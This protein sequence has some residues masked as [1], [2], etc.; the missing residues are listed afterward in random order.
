MRDQQKI[1]KL[2]LLLAKIVIEERGMPARPDLRRQPNSHLRSIRNSPTVLPLA[3]TEPTTDSDSQQTESG[4]DFKSIFQMADS[5]EEI[6][7][8]KASKT[9]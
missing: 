3:G 8:Q 9:E 5:I 7:L 6:E 4:M 2:D 1:H